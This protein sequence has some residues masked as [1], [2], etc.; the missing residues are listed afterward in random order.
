APQAPSAALRPGADEMKRDGFAPRQTDLVTLATDD[1]AHGLTIEPA[2][3]QDLV[4]VDGDVFRLGFGE[5]A[6]HQAERKRPRLRR[7]IAHAVHA[8]A[9]LLEHFAPHRFLDRLARLDEARERGI[10]PAREA[11]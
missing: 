3:G 10:V 4:S 11:L 5:A 7:E 2:R 8:H 9:H 1:A 6:D